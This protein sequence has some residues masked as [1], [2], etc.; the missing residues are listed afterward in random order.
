M[1]RTILTLGWSV[2]GTLGLSVVLSLP[3]TTWATETDQEAPVGAVGGAVHADPFTGTAT[4]SIPIEV[5]PGRSGIQPD[6][7]LVYGSANGN[8][9]L[10][11]GWKL[12]KGV[13]DRQTKF[14]VDYSG[15]DYVFRLSGIN[16][17]MVNIGNNEY[18]A[19]VEG[20]F[21]RIK[22]LT[23]PDGKPYFEATDKTGKKFIFGKVAATR[24]ADPNNANSIFR[25][26]LERVEDVHGNY[27][28]LS[29][30]P[31][32]GQ[33]YLRQIDYTGNGAL[34]PTNQVKFYLEDRPDAPPM[35][36]PNFLMTTAKRLKTIEITANGTRVA[37]Y[38]IDYEPSNT[39]TISSVKRYGNDA[40][41][42]GTGTI[43]G[44]TS[45]P[46]FTVNYPTGGTAF[47]STPNQWAEIAQLNSAVGDVNGDGKAD[48]VS[49]SQVYLS[50]GSAFSSPQNWGYGG[51]ILADVNGD[52]K[53]DR[54]NIYDSGYGIDAFVALSTGTGFLLETS[55]AAI[56]QQ[57]S[58]VGD[59]NG[60]GKADVVSGNQVYLSTGSAFSSPQN[61]G[62]GGNILADVNGDGKADR[63][64]IYDSGYGIDAFVA[65]STG[66][67]FL[68]ETSW[69]EIAGTNVAV[70]DV[71]G[72][73]RADLVV[74]TTIGD[75]VYSS[76]G[77]AFSAAQNWGFG[78][79]S[80]LRD[81]NGDGRADGI[82]F[83]DSG[84][85]I[86]VSVGLSTQTGA[87]TLTFDNGYGGS[88]TINF[89]TLNA[90]TQIPFPWRIVESI[91]TTDG[92]NHTATTTYDYS[93]GFYYLPE[94]DFRGFHQV[95]VTG[96]LGPNNERTVTTTWFHQGNDTD[97][98]VNNP[99]VDDGYLKGAPYQVEVRDGANQ[100]YS[101]TTTTYQAP[102][103]TT[104]APFFAPPAS[105]V[106]DICDGNSCGKQIR[107]DFTY[108]PYGNVTREEHWG[109]VGL[110]TDDRTVTR[111]FAPNTSAWI[112][113]LPTSETIYQGLG[114]STQMARTDFYYDGTGS[115]SAPGG[116]AQPTQG[117]LTRVK[118]SL[119]G[120]TDPETGMTYDAYGNVICTRD[121]RGNMTTMSYDASKTFATVV[122]NALGHVTSTSYYGV[123][124]VGQTTGL[125]GQ[126]KS[127]TDPNGSTTTTE[128]DVFGRRTTVTQ[129]NG[130][131]TTTSYN[132][133]GT[134]G[135][136]HVRTDSQ[137]GL[138][139]WTYF[140]GLGR[141]TKTRSTG[142]DSK[143]V[144]ASIQY[145]NRGAVTQQ[146]LPVF[147]PASPNQWTT[148]EY[149]PLGR[150]IKTTNPDGS[151]GLACYDDWVTVAID[152]NHHRHR[153]VRDAYGRV[154]TVQEYTGTYTTCTTSVGSPYSTTT[155]A[156]DV[157]GNLKTLTDTKGNVSTMTYDTLSRKTAMHDPDMGNWSYVYDAAGNLTRQ[158][159]AK[160]QQI[161]FQY[162]ALNR[163]VQK[164][165][166]TQQ[167]L[168]AGNVNYVYDGSTDF[169]KGRLQKVLD[170]SGITTFYYDNMGQVTR[171][172]KAVS[173]T[174]YTTQT[175]YDTLGRVLTLTYPDASTVT[176]TYNG[177]QLKE[178][179]EGS[180]IYAA[181]SGFN[182]QG[183][184]SRLTLGNGVTTDYTY[185]P[186]NYRL[187]T[188]KTVKGS[189]TLQ[190]L[191][192][193][194][195][196][197]GN[198]T[199][200]TDPVHGHQTFN[201]D[202][203]DRLTSAAGPYGS[204]T[205]SYDQIGNMTD[206][207]RVGTYTYPAS[208][209]SSIRPHAATTAGAHTYT[210]DANGNMI[211][212]AGRTISY[213]YENRPTSIT[214]TGSGGG[215]GGG[216]GSGSSGGETVSLG[217][218]NDG[219]AA[220][221]GATGTGF[222]LYSAEAVSTRFAANP[223]YVTNSDHVIA[224]QFSGGVWRYDNNNGLY[225]FTPEASDVL[226][227]AVDFSTDTVQ[228]LE[229]V[230][231]VEQGIAKG[232]ASGDLTFLANWWA[233]MTNAGEFTVNGT[234]FVKNGAASGG[235]GSSGGGETV[236]LGAINDGVAARDG[237][238]GT[239][240]LLYSAEAV[241]TR[242]AA[243]PPYVT[244]SDHVIAV[245]FSGG[246]WRYDNNNGLY[247]FTP[248]ASDVLLAAVDFSTDTVQSL[249]DVDEVEQGIAKGY[250]SGDL[251]FLA[252]WWAGM[253]NAGEFT[254]NGTSFVKN[255]AASGGGGSSGGGETVSLGAI[256]DGVAARDGATG[257]GFILYSQESVHSRFSANPPYV[258][259]SDHVIAVQ[260]SG[261]VWRY[262]NN[263]GL[264]AFT[265]QASDVLLAA[266][267][268]SNDTITGLQGVDSVEQGIA[269]GYAS[270]DLTF[271][272]NWWNGGANAGEFTVDGTSFVTN[273]TS[274]GSGGGS[275]GG[276]L[277]TTFTYDGDGGRVSKTVNDGS[278]STTTIYIGKLYVCEGT[279]CARM[280]F[281]GGQ[282]VAMQQVGTGSISYFHADHLGSTSVLTDGNGNSEEDLV[283]YPYGETFTNTGTADVAYK[284][285][286]KERDGSTGLY[287]YEARYYDAAL[288]RFISA[289]TIVPDPLDP[290]SLNRYTYAANNPVLY[291]DPSGHCPICFA[292]GFAVIGGV[293]AGFQSDWDAG[294][295]FKGAFVGFVG[296]AAAGGGGFGAGLVFSN[297]SSAT[298]SLVAATLATGIHTGLVGYGL[299]GLLGPAGGWGNGNEGF[300]LAA[301]VA[302]GVVGTGFQV[303]GGILG[304][305]AWG[306]IG[307]IK[308]GMI[309]GNIVS[310]PVVGAVSAAIRGEDPGAGAL[311]GLARSAALLG[312][313]A[314]ELASQGV[315]PLT[316]LLS[317]TD[318]GRV[319]VMAA[320]SRGF[321]ANR[322]ATRGLVSE[323]VSLGESSGNSSKLDIGTA[324]S[325]ANSIIDGAA[326][327]RT[328]IRYGAGAAHLEIVRLLGG[329]MP[330]GTNL[331]LRGAIVING[332]GGVFLAAGGGHMIGSGILTIYPRAGTYFGDLTFDLTHSQP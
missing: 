158:T 151:R 289:D 278:T 127:V 214:T 326:I 262:D 13:I 194:F 253:T 142:T 230:D 168:G 279:S 10:G 80:I 293:A 81:G 282:R 181:Y 298:G 104:Q 39:S 23:A 292:V 46:A 55:W 303:T 108:D 141:T 49:G 92:N 124:G 210:Y 274:G 183:Q 315:N 75:L 321:I 7:A 212:G 50:T 24:V 228:S 26:C 12:E 305:N 171:T 319:E 312:V 143:I 16:V 271:T 325:G 169:R 28:T 76:T 88:S 87:N 60:D 255:G 110:P 63:I 283:Y 310:G 198:V 4:T 98:G 317:F 260:F 265:P 202:G 156:Y 231:E 277:T 177:P 269:K 311:I 68:L 236:S 322:A 11:M 42:D 51:N 66:T 227:A 79:V 5:P 306:G 256:N 77:N 267:D 187:K 8:G 25:W 74:N 328:S 245:Q 233:G 86:T 320:S 234:S 140:D 57:N 120:G 290:Q 122:T 2:I 165:Y 287:F 216:G 299:Q 222:L 44:G 125:Y 327:I 78:G 114:T 107:T 71:N 184:P 91:V 297:V 94:R 225:A 9:W 196:D 1:P 243:N 268:F 146:S 186:N 163:R 133:F 238:T 162:D 276:S 52:G 33:A 69:A 43:T 266:V 313:T 82:S 65:L 106:T 185:D 219:V 72:D 167:P 270:G 153:T 330:L 304:L 201:Y 224:V 53:A 188:L 32:Q 204:L 182:A 83:Y 189:L 130:F 220:R 103:S 34:T 179:K 314:I 47:F 17:E 89:T 175:T 291:N 302:G 190:D 113:G 207:S 329:S 215:S 218:I 221:D 205:Y 226:L 40:A 14:G 48:V 180:T 160:G 324:V 134:V 19:K 332:A 318:D 223:P 111:T 294:A 206:N 144:T 251:T 239:G 264:Y 235:G 258:T 174:T 199:T 100:L 27:M 208:G 192:Y 115:C 22:K 109:D 246:V 116:S 280:I 166:G 285:T 70:G 244:N 93:D 261:G 147:E 15:D 131:W 307:G 154:V 117:T 35:Y 308:A 95:T 197:G 164:D 191:T 20:G 6:L 152:A 38:K 172:D 102:T 211:S 300:S 281:A 36:V 64:N 126:V 145:D 96:P 193:T 73:G 101:K 157:L 21:T 284:Y 301:G 257:S 3:L 275:G 90:T 118:Q 331:A 128:Y 138:S 58:A 249:E 123:N 272:P 173:G 309:A 129:P 119:T 105:T 149:D 121:A 135:S 241:S 99:N 250:A 176:H 323:R 254:V 170:G 30:T 84:Y 252:N 137:A 178:V 247:A 232:Y 85:G 97:V 155:Y 132:S 62:Y 316:Y 237:A 217:A 203:L 296:G 148:S 229:D 242:F 31:D 195:D 29:Y 263:N 139:T 295:I 67:G 112:L 209:S 273:A 61:W 37:A 41:L 150:T 259:N 159:D 286:G 240:F 288:G 59:V 200:L 213:D 45:L 18:R 54:I 136:Q 56:A 248:E 161:H